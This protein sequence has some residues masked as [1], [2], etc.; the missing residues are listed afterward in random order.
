M[1][2]FAE[3]DAQ[4]FCVA[5][6]PI[7][8]A[9]HHRNISVSSQRGKPM[10]AGPSRQA[11]PRRRPEFERQP[12]AAPR[13]SGGGTTCIAA[14][15]A[16]APQTKAS[17]RG[18]MQPGRV[19]F[20]GA[21]GR[22][23]GAAAGHPLFLAAVIGELLISAR[24]RGH[25]SFST[26]VPALLESSRGRRRHSLVRGIRTMR[27]RALRPRNIGRRPPPSRLARAP[28]IPQQHGRHS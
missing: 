11:R 3:D 19:R 9:A 13:D 6:E 17:G 28:T 14:R 23:A 15:L 21:A 27:R 8:P 25:S 20:G 4:C 26:S 10:S 16:G 1:Q 22:R 2:R 18:T 24:R 12:P 5:V 7:E